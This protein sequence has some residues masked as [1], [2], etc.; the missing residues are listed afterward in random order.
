MNSKKL[1][2]DKAV[3]QVMDGM[4]VGLGTGSTALY[5]IQRIG[6]RMR[7]G[8]KITA[9]ASSLG[10][11]ALATEEGIPLVGMTEIS[12]IDLYIDGADEVDGLFH[13]IKGGGGALTREKILAYNSQRF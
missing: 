12:A 2:A 5:A 1:A 11:A 7:E 10:T 13:A 3:E 8:L 9:V 4:V 6:E